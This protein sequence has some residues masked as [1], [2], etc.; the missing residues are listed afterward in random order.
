M[1]LS[2]C[3]SVLACFNSAQA[4]APVARRTNALSLSSPSSSS[5]QQ[6][7]S[8]NAEALDKVSKK[9]TS[10][11]PELKEGDLTNEI[12]LVQP[13]H[14]QQ[15]REEEEG[16]DDEYKKGILT[17]AFIC[18]LNSSLAPV[19]HIVFAGENGPPP[20]LL[21][22]VVSI[23]ALLGLLIGGSFLD[24]SLESSSALAESTEEK[25]Q[26][27]SF[28]GGMELGLWKGLGTKKS[29]FL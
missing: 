26:W 24:S 8:S 19:W 3:L 28:R 22:A 27:K 10:K 6:R 17:I 5:S 23:V 13:L 18:L 29:D 9:S 4:F 11:S 1:K 15:Q 7:V 12:Q 2:R 16:S 14:Q 21:N 25:W 20:L